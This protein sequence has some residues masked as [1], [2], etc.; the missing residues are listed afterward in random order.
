MM[1]NGDRLRQ[2]T[3]EELAEVVEFQ[4]CSNDK[5]RC[6]K[7][8]QGNSCIHS[9]QEAFLEWLKQEVEQNES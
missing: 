5:V 2:M 4:E 3:D 6:P 7:L 9:C 8:D 1:T